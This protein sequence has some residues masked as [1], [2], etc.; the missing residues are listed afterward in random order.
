M[1]QNMQRIPWCVYPVH[2]TSPILKYTQVPVSI[3]SNRTTVSGYMQTFIHSIILLSMSYYMPVYFQACKGASP[4]ATGVDAF[5]MVLLV[6]PV[7]IIAGATVAVSKR[8]RP[9]MW[10]GW[11]IIV[12]GNSLL[13]ILKVDTSR[14]MAVGIQAVSG[15]GLGLL[16]TTTF[17]PVLAPLPLS[18]NAQAV[19]FLIFMRTFGQVTLKSPILRH[20]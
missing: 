6:A 13:T 1:K 11:C 15:F 14:S 5:G 9:Q 8:Y 17:F 20:L 4:T 10:M 16:I 19:A 3:M 18:V 12:A 7:G 2:A